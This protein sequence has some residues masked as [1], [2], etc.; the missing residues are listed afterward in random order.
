MVYPPDSNL[1][2]PDPVDS[3]LLAGIVMKRGGGGTDGLTVR[4]LLM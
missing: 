1:S 2:C 3:V 4:T